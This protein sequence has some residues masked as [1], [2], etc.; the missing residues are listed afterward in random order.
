M[1]LPV[2]LAPWYDFRDLSN[3]I[4]R[5]LRWLSDIGPNWLVYVVSAVI[6]G[7]AIF[8]FVA[9]TAV[10]NIWV[11]RRV[12]ARIQVRRGPNRAGPWGLLQ[13]IADMTKLMQKEALLPRAGDPV[14]FLLAPILAFG[15][16]LLVWGVFPFGKGMTFVDLNVGVLYIIAVTSVTTI[17]LFMAGWSS[18]NKYSLLGAIRVIAM[19]LS[20][21]IPLVLALLGAVLFAGTMSLSGIVAW[22]QD[23]RI[24]LFLVQPLAFIIY[25]VCATAEINRTPTDIA[26]AESEI[27]AGYHTEYSGIQFGLFYAVELVN[28]MALGSIAATLFFGGW[29]LFG[30][31]RW[32]PGWI[33]FVTKIYL[34]YFLLIWLR[35][36]LPR[37]RID[38]LMAFAWKFLLPLA[39]VNLMLGALE[40]LLW[41]EYD[42]SAGLVLPLFSAVNLSLA[43]LL[44]V[45][46]MRLMAFPFHRLPSRA[47]LVHD[48]SVIAP[49][50]PASAG[51]GAA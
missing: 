2:L 28:A 39:L 4:E 27:V 13:P 48:I 22:Q 5:L 35:G 3:A 10:A 23:M 6:G 31:D 17:V 44:I 42:L 1:S 46:W 12:V 34:I 30:L 33:I 40:V 50:A 26:E 37:L 15:P 7:T 51:G 19:L 45:G 38:Q 9:A 41:V 18:N 21:E 11:E 14:V 32:I 24:W 16:A 29:W 8:L 20:Y 25:F 49:G 36:T 43:V 47:R